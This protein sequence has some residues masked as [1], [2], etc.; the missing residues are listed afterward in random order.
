MLSNLFNRQAR[1]FAGIDFLDLIPVS[2]VD[3]VQEE[4]G[5]QVILK[6]PRYRDFLFGRLIQPRLGPDKRFVRMKLDARGSYLWARMN[7]E[8]CIGD[9][10]AGF[11][12]AFPQDAE[13]AGERISGYL[14]NMYDQKLLDFENL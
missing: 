12:E 10:V 2:R 4:G 1:R 5:D 13:Q 8:R 11:Q 3:F 7:G 9:L 6:I 14:Y